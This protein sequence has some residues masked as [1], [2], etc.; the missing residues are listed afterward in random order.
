MLTMKKG[1][2]IV[3]IKDKEEKTFLN[4]GYKHCPKKI[5]KDEKNNCKKQNCDNKFCFSVR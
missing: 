4:R 1:K 5:W 2:D 3:R